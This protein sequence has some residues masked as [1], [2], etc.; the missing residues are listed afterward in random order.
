MTKKPRIRGILADGEKIKQLR[1]AARI[2]QKVLADR[3]NTTIRTLQRAEGGKSIKPSILAMI[4]N[5]LETDIDES[6][7]DSLK[8]STNEESPSPC[9]QVLSVKLET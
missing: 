7:V 2:P 4:A 1:E 5:A 6:S 8:I 3:A 9:P